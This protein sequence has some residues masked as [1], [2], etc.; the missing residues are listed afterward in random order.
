MLKIRLSGIDPNETPNVSSELIARSSALDLIFD[1]FHK[2]GTLAPSAGL[3]QRV[4]PPVC[5]TFKNNCK[6]MVM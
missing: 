2:A 1:Y 6:S 3:A 4:R 5:P